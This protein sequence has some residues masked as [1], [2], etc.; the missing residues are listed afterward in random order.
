[1]GC[2]SFNRSFEGNSKLFVGELRLKAKARGKPFCHLEESPTE[3]RAWDQ[4]RRL[5]IPVLASAAT[6]FLIEE[7]EQKRRWHIYWAERFRKECGPKLPLEVNREDGIR[8]LQAVRDR[9]GWNDWRLKN[10]AMAIAAVLLATRGEDLKRWREIGGWLAGKVQERG[11]GAAH[12]VA[13]AAL[14]GELERKL[15]YEIRFRHYSLRTEKSYLDW[16]KRFAGYVGNGDLAQVAPERVKAY[17][18]HLAV[19]TQVSESTQN[20]AFS[21]LLFVY[22]EVLRSDLGVLNEVTR[23]KKKDRIPEVL[24]REEVGEVLAHLDSEWQ[25]M[26]KLMYGAGLRLMECLRLRV[27]DLDFGHQAVVVRNGKGRKDRITVLP[28]SLRGL[29]QEQIAKVR[30]QHGLDIQAGYGEVWIE[31]A[32]LRKYPNLQKELS[33]Q[34]VFPANQFPV[35]PRSEKRRRHHRQP[36]GLQRAVK[37]AARRAGLL[38]RVSPHAFRHSFATHL[39]EGGA[40]IRTVQEL[41]GHADV[42]TTMIY[43][44]VLNRPGIAVRSPLD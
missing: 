19:V 34:W 42:S 21:A 7:D 22:R 3:Q 40:D 6:A 29:L 1:M 41:L 39:L 9:K 30:A 16:A 2:P 14:E 18:E 12:T 8:F 15:I 43:T 32:L 28:A 20:Q 4:G 44:H 37:E 5:W 17:L 23:A 38:K 36:D 26:G 33:W 10:V 24:T 25:V 27:K 11:I 35:D 31:E 13:R